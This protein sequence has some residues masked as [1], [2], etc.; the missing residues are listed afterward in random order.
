MS[1]PAGTEPAQRRGLGERLLEVVVAVLLTALVALAG[2]VTHRMEVDAFPLGIVIGILL[3]LTGAILV[4]S[5]S[6]T[7][8]LL[9]YGG[10]GIGIVLLM[11][12][13]GPGG[14]VLVTSTPRAMLWILTM[15]LAAAIGWAAPRG[16]FGQD[17]VR[18]GRRR[19]GRTDEAE[20][21]ADGP[22]GVGTRPADDDGST[23]RP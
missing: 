5:V 18:L 20:R 15:P 16:W 9:V 22:D 3:A 23:P 6:G 8:A 21:D 19:S 14:D 12:Y 11:T 7:S 2:T 17:P 4:R 13:W 1:S 10:L